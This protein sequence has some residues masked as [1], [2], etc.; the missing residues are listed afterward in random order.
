[1][2]PLNLRDFLAHCSDEV[3]SNLAPAMKAINVA[4][5][6]FRLLPHADGFIQPDHLT[7][8]PDGMLH[9]EVFRA[10]D[11]SFKVFVSIWAPGYW[12]PIF[13]HGSWGAVGV[14]YGA[15]E[16]RSYKAPNQALDR[17]DD[18]GLNLVGT[19]I[20]GEGAVA[21][22]APEDGQ[23]VRLGVPEDREPVACLHFYG[24]AAGLAHVYNADADNR[25]TSAGLLHEGL[26]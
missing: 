12:S 9:N 4:Q 24:G 3:R 18:L 1:M 13:D 19:Q 23:I 5:L 2:D 10:P 21:T 20:L 22:F 25:K 17:H 26:E 6:M 8:D 15:L 16:Q 7:A 14:I 11:Q